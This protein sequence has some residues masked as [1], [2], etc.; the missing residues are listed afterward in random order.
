[1]VKYN[2][3]SSLEDPNFVAFG[4]FVALAEVDEI[5]AIVVGIGVEANGSVMIVDS[6]DAYPSKIG[7]HTKK[8]DK[9]INIINCIKQ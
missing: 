4:F 8:Q 2:N 9:S 3:C 1:M 7:T 5:V 6:I